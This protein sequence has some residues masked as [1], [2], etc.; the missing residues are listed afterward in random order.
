MIRVDVLIVGA[1][2][3]GARAAEALRAYGYPGSVM[4]AGDEPHAPYERP[5]LSKEVLTQGRDAPDISLRP[6]HAWSE[7][8]IRLRLDSPVADVDLDAHLATVRG[9]LV[10]WE[11]LVIA[12][13]AR[14]RRI[15]GISDVEGVHHVRTLTEARRLRERLEP[16]T[17][18][19]LIGAGFVGV[20]LASSARS[21]GVEVEVIELE[22]FPFGRLLGEAVGSRVAAR[23]RDAGVR[24][25]LGVGV[26][27]VV[28][29]GDVLAGVRLS[30]ATGVPCDELVVGVGA[31][32]NTELL[33]GQLPLA[34]DG[35]IV[36]DAAGR[37]E[38]QDVF[39]CG[40]V[41]SA[42]RPDL[43]RHQ[44]FEHWSS[45][46]AGARA[47]AAAITGSE[48]PDHGVPYFWS[49]QFGWRLQLV[50]HPHGT[51]R[52]VE[53]RGDEGFV[54]RYEGSDGSLLGGLAI[55]RPD[56]LGAL[57]SEVTEAASGQLATTSG[58]S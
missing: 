30:D 8:E 44:R 37:T 57:R 26:Q 18:L 6:D 40:D 17:R 51:P 48:I 45:A 3:A 7:R 35:G 39:A 28:M 19:A 56:L 55:N 41:A 47:V 43:G 54:V 50:G 20:E 16:G 4:V 22:Q 21:L 14:A 29:A 53:D 58:R 31:T 27:D 24:L 34:D 46:T 32:P 49:D 15:P 1:G 9:E 38:H 13:G 2:L 52:L 10:R 5:A 33:D 36:T 11:R 25:N 12:T 42:W 23:M